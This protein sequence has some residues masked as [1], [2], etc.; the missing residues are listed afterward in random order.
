MIIDLITI[1]VLD[2]G[3][4]AS[5]KTMKPKTLHVTSSDI[6]EREKRYLEKV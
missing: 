6:M 2:H 4:Q 3:D 1:Y 5:R